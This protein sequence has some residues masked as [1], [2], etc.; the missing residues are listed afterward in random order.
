MS[1]LFVS[2]VLCLILSPALVAGPADLPLDLKNPRFLDGGLITGGQPTQKDL[3]QLKE[4]GVTTVINLRH[5]D[6]AKKHPD[7]SVPARFNFLENQVAETLG[8]NYVNLPI[9]SA[10]DLTAENAKLLDEA[11]A[12][13]PGPVLLHCGSGNRVGA[14]MT[15]RAYHVQGKSPDEALAVGRAAGLTG[16]EP[17]VRELLAEA[18]K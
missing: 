16:L 4:H 6:E 8:L 18:A 3:K 9:S 2:L 17:K 12:A 7:P 15:L 14:L 10:A 13:A 11:L 5:P 1:R